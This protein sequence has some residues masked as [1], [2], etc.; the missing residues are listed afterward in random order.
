MNTKD[1]NN[2]PVG[3]QN[4]AGKFLTAEDFGF[5]LNV[6]GQNLGRKQTWIIELNTDE[7]ACMKNHIGRYL[8]ADKYGSVKCE[9][10]TQTDDGKFT[11]E[12]SPD[13]T[14]R[15]TF[16]N[17]KYGNYL[18]GSD[19]KV[20]CLSKNGSEEEMSIWC[21]PMATHPHFV[22]YSKR[23]KRYFGLEKKVC[24]GEAILFSFWNSVQESV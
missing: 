22:L 3:L 7:T 16:K 13:G 10:E 17:V 4:P 2:W 15:W 20:T 14:G 1:T 9:S 21:V 8:T 12:Y 6:L 11:I 18:G 5:E 24:L 23:Q 19:K